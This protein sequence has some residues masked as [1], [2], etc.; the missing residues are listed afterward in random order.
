MKYPK[1]LTLLPCYDWSKKYVSTLSD[2]IYLLFLVCA[3]SNLIV[4]SAVNSNSPLKHP[5]TNLCH[6]KLDYLTDYALNYPVTLYLELLYLIWVNSS[7]LFFVTSISSPSFSQLLTVIFTLFQC[8][9]NLKTNVLYWTC[10]KFSNPIVFVYAQI[11]GK[12]LTAT[13]SI[14]S[15]F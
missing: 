8:S 1:Y 7:T 11:Q 5:S 14:I 15:R 9:L 13:I 10:Y 4:N 6:R 12:N 3:H 2:C